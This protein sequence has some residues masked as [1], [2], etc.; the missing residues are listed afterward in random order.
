MCSLKLDVAP[1]FS[2][3]SKSIEKAVHRR[4][5]A[6]RDIETPTRR[7]L[8]VDAKQLTWR[9]QHAL[10][11]RASPQL[12]DGFARAKLCPDEHPGLRASRATARK[13]ER[14]PSSCSQL[15]GSQPHPASTSIFCELASRR[16]SQVES[17]GNSSSRV[18]AGRA[19]RRLTKYPVPARAS[20]RPAATSEL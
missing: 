15:D 10:V 9:K 7:R 18:A 16:R 13:A 12:A 5:V 1:A 8:A 17:T 6:L 20:M 14:T 19:R 3:G 11:H 4:R 2:G